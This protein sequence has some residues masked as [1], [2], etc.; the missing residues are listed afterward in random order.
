MLLWVE[1]HKLMTVLRHIKNDGLIDA[2]PRKARAPS[3]W[4]D[5]RSML[6]TD[7]QNARDLLDRHGHHHTKWSNLIDGRIG[8]IESTYMRI[9]MR[10]N[11]S[12]S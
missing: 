5:W 8:R 10:L 7:A 4:Q 2:L 1:A 6:C 11:A 9:V 3:S 12:V